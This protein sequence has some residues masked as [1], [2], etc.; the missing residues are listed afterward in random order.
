M[1]PSVI[2]VLPFLI[3]IISLSLMPVAGY[4]SETISR[5]KSEARKGSSIAIGK[6]PEQI[7]FV[8]NDIKAWLNTEGDWYIQGY[9]NHNKLLC[10]HYDLGIRFGTGNPGCTNV[11][12]IS[13]EEYVSHLRQCNQARMGHGGGNRS[14]LLKNNYSKITCAER[15]V[16]CKGKCK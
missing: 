13:E 3:G 11:Q 6:T 14:G 10:A 4:S 16:K 2:R 8:F 7:N 5:T 12:W 15:I 9:I 1:N